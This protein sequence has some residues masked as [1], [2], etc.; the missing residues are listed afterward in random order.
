AL[1]LQ[2]LG[3]NF[4]GSPDDI[5]SP[6][7]NLEP[8]AGVDLPTC[9]VDFMWVSR[10]RRQGK[11]IV[12]LGEC[13][14]QG[15]INPAEFESDIE[16]LRRVADALPRRRF[17]TFIVLSKLAPFTPEEIQS[18]RT[19]NGQ[20]Q[21]RVI[22]LTARELEPYWIYDRT[23]AELGID[24]HGSRPEDLAQATDTIYFRNR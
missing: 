9:E 23:K 6:S 18:A 19:L 5:Y 2:Q 3:T 14:D 15:P 12:L 4:H 20:Y 16:N 11:T 1:T 8:K 17:E 10:Q 13:K 21:Q 22:L 7:L 24:L